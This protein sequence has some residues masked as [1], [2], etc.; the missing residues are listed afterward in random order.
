[1]AG[2][3]GMDAPYQYKF[4]NRGISGNRIV[5]LYARIKADMINLKPDVMSILIGVNDVWHEYSYQ[6]GVSAE[7][8]EIVY[9]LLIE[10]LQQALPELKLFILEPFVLPGGATMNNEEHPARWD[11]FRSEV[12]LRAKAAKRVAEKYNLPFVPLQEMFDKVNAD[13]PEMGYWLRD[14]VHPT[15]AGHELIKQQWLKAFKELQ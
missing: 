7:K 4:Y 8:F 2:E 1:V 6:N 10:E 9:S 11:F 5:D 14:G 12:E 3:L 13:A 15:P